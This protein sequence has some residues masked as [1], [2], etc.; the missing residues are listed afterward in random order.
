M[1]LRRGPTVPSCFGPRPLPSVDRREDHAKVV[2]RKPGHRRRDDGS[3]HRSG[4]LRRSHEC[5][6]AA[7]A[8]A[9]DDRSP[10]P[11][12]VA[13]APRRLS[14]NVAD[15]NA[16]LGWRGSGAVPYRRERP[17]RPRR[18]RRRVGIGGEALGGLFGQ[19]SID[20]AQRLVP[21][22]CEL[23]E[24]PLVGAASC[25]TFGPPG[26]DGDRRPHQAKGQHR[27]AVHDDG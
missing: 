22:A 10:D 27:R 9:D 25:S 8:D 18:H 23:A 26:A 14:R 6:R 2:R 4:R 3:G 7:F 12:G 24:G 1:G 21:G 20:L 19:R 16:D 15:P 11:K 17:E 5:R 13:V